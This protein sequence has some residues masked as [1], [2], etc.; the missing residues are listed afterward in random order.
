M[1]EKTWTVLVCL[2]ASVAI[3]H[4]QQRS[5][6]ENLSYWL[7]R[8]GPAGVVPAPFEGG[9]TLRIDQG[10]DLLLQVCLHDPRNWVQDPVL[11]RLAHQRPLSTISCRELTTPSLHMVFYPQPDGSRQARVHFDLHGPRN[12]AGHLSEVLRNRLTNGRT[13]EYDVYRSLIEHNPADTQEAPPPRYDFSAHL[14]DYLHQ[15][16]GAG[17]IAGSLF[18]SV[19]VSLV[20]RSPDWGEGRERYVDHFGA[21]VAARTLRQSIEFGAGALLQQDEHFSPSSA[22]GIKARLKSALYRSFFVPGREGDEFAFPRVAA[23]VGTGWAV[24]EYHPFR[25]GNLNPWVQTGEVLSGYVARSF[26]HE[27]G[28]DISFRL[29]ELRERK[30][31]A[32]PA[33][34]PG[35]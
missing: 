9:R 18:S 20:S 5:L 26:W 33:A 29:R 34:D 8:G 12:P 32:A 30:H 21:A 16:F 24:H 22:T 28:P 2:L 19:A 7:T 10:A 6:P 15:T 1:R 3:S 17:A 35:P 27:F 31:R 13:L 4:A 11:F 25:R 23:A 14:H